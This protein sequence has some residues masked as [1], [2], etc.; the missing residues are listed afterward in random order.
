[1]TI[2][3]GG[4]DPATPAASP[5]AAEPPIYAFDEV[6]S[7]AGGAYTDLVLA[8]WLP[9]LGPPT[10]S[11]VVSAPAPPPA[12][13]RRWPWRRPDRAE[14]VIHAGLAR[15][16]VRYAH[17]HPMPP[18]MRLCLHG[19]SALAAIAGDEVFGS[20]YLSVQRG[21]LDLFAELA[22]M[23]DQAIEL[24]ALRIG[25]EADAHTAADVK[26]L[27]RV[28]HALT[29]RVQ[30]WRQYLDELH[31]LRPTVIELRRQVAAADARSAAIDGLVARAVDSTGELP[32]FTSEI[33]AL[34]TEIADL[35]N[36]L[37]G[38]GPS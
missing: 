29:E 33:V 35:V 14:Q 28:W 16:R 24:Y 4:D 22:S 7:L 3:A 27:L 19:A 26:Q 21:R 12:R 36:R 18:E 30:V 2:D 32:A 6:V 31:E 38:I 15:A 37:G 5:F 8:R 17:G 1:M 25:V 20:D 11:N 10:T 13:R 23:T 34:R 9:D